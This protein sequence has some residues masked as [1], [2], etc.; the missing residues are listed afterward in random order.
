MSRLEDLVSGA[1][2]EG[3]IPREPVT[4]V[5]GSKH[6]PL[7]RSFWLGKKKGKEAYVKPVIDK[8]KGQYRF[9]VRFGK[10]SDGFDPDVGTETCERKKWADEA[11]SYNG[12]VVSWPEIER[13]ARQLE[14]APVAAEQAELFE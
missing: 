11:R 14:T 2:V 8:V 7:V 6:V 1:A 3:I 12:L 10:P 4:A 5:K 9:E 13:L